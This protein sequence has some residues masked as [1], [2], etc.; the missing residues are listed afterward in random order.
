MSSFTK[1]ALWLGTQTRQ[2]CQSNSLA[3][4]GHWLSSANDQS[5]SFRISAQA[6]PLAGTQSSKICA[7]A[8]LSPSPLLYL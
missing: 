3:S 7:F 2:N 8:A 1:T 4:W 6:P 5:H